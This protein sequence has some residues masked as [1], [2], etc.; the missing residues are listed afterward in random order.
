MEESGSE[1]QGGRRAKNR[2]LPKKTTPRVPPK[3]S[4][5]G[6]YDNANQRLAEIKA[7]QSAGAVIDLRPKNLTGGN[8]FDNIKDTVAQV[9]NTNQNGGN[10]LDNIANAVTQVVDNT[11]Q[12][13]GKKKKRGRSK[14]GYCGS[15]MSSA[16]STQ[17]T[18]QGGKKKPSAYNLFMKEHMK[19][20][21]STHP[22]LSAPEKMKIIG[23]LWKKKNSK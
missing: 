20:M 23:A 17:S 6:E 18:Q 7:S 19:K 21:K 1:M 13:G 12:D 2:R 4:R 16:Q 11:K 14:G 8:L 5:G 22:K 9:I 3:K 10:L 15:S